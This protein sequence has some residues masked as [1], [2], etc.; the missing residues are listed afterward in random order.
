MRA[1]VFP[2]IIP[3]STK[4]IVVFNS[5]PIVMQSVNHFRNMFHQ[6]LTLTSSSSSSFLSSLK[7]IAFSS[8]SNELISLFCFTTFQ[9][10]NVL[11]NQF[12]Q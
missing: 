1:V 6:F 11:S 7:K 8:S 2:F 3:M 10:G 9:P 12:C 5:A 4:N